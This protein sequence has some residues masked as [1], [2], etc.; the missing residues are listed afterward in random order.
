MPF[1]RPLDLEFSISLLKPSATM[2]KRKRERGHPCL[3]PL[4]ELKKEEGELLTKTTKEADSTQL[5]IQLTIWRLIQVWIMTH[6]IK[7]QLTLSYAF[8]KS[9][10]NTKQGTFFVFKE[11]KY[12]RVDETTS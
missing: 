9:N 11:W 7:V 12:S 10:F 5:V 6:L 3:S 2:R 1:I 8:E 4:D